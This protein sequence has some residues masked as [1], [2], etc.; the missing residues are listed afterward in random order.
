MASKKDL[1]LIHTIMKKK[2]MTSKEVEEIY[3]V[4]NKTAR[5]MIALLNEEIKLY[6]AKFESK[7]GKGYKLT[8]EQQ[9]KFEEFIKKNQQADVMTVEDR[10]EVLIRMFTET[11]EYLKAETLA[12]QLYVSPQI[13]SKALKKAE[14][15]LN[16]F[17]L[18]IERR[19]HYGMR[20][21]GSEYD[22]RRCLAT[23]END[24]EFSTADQKL[25]DTMRAIFQK[26][27]VKMSEA[28]LRSFLETIQ[29]ALRRIERGIYVEFDQNKLSLS[30]QKMVEEN[31]V[32][33]EECIKVL[34]DIYQLD[35]PVSEKYYTAL[36]IADKKYYE[37]NVNLLIDEEV[38]ALV[39][40]I[41]ESIYETYQLDLRQDL[42]FYMML[43]KHL[44]PLKVRLQYGTMIKN[45]ILKEVKSEYP[46]ALSIAK[47]LNHII[48]KYYGKKLSE[49][50]LGYIA[51]AIQLTMDKKKKGKNNKKNILLVCASGNVFSRFFKY[52]FKEMFEDCINEAYT[53]DYPDLKAYDFR[54]ID[55][56]FST[57]PLDLPIP[58][59]AF[60]VDYYPD[61]SEMGN[62]RTVLEQPE[63]MIEK[64]FSEEL[65]LSGLEMTSKENVI[66]EMCSHV[67]DIRHVSEEFYDLVMKREKLLQTAMGNLVAV[68]HPYRSITDHT[69]ICT[70]ILKK[71]IYWNETEKV[72]VIF[73][74]SVSQ[75]D[76]KDIESFYEEFF[77]VALSKKN[78]EQ[79]I[80][81][82]T[83][84]ELIQIIRNN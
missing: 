79:L 31:L 80:N 78:I 18:Y 61:E 75:N 39:T 65:F 55:Y 7:P 1:K 11:E 56:V 6:G 81:N 15:Y 24:K 28:A 26:N 59:P 84:D 69:M 44:I 20:L 5:K 29:V 35:F 27:N 46:F 47:G 14:N 3:A 73:M 17:G 36:N 12:D 63:N 82:P 21:A 34:K 62:I 51:L 74:I 22:I 49:D 48:E 54:N 30:T 42:E 50:E 37:K 66:R 41:L 57:V 38:N 70:A 2:S 53:C 58:V 43:A 71:P 23:L 76:M 16:N 8:I 67:Q 83:Y 13:I 68:P 4:S 33:A 60:Q 64:Y 19:P 10:P 45:P 40:E 25:E 9:D 52:R 77:K 32:T 72:Q